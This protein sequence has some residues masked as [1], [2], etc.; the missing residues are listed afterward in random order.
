MSD[1][2][3]TLSASTMERG[4]GGNIVQLADQRAAEER[5]GN[6]APMASPWLADLLNDG[7]HRN[8]ARRVAEFRGAVRRSLMATSKEY[9]VLA[10]LELAKIPGSEACQAELRRVLSA[11]PHYIVL[12]KLI[13]SEAYLGHAAGEYPSPK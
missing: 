2:R 7:S 9:R 3:G 8:L 6:R 12:S 13:E 4:Y 11:N 10:S 1:V 5:Q